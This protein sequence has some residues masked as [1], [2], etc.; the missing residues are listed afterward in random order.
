MESSIGTN[1][2]TLRSIRTS[3]KNVGEERKRTTVL[4]SYGKIPKAG[5]EMVDV[6]VAMVKKKQQEFQTRTAKV[7]AELT[8]AAALKHH[9]WV[10]LFNDIGKPYLATA[11]FDG[12]RQ[13]IDIGVEGLKPDT[14]VW[15][16][17]K[18]LP[19]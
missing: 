12:V 10:L 8:T 5:E 18:T 7:L 13:R 2:E 16:V 19:N 9:D 14:P 15:K 6:L 3:G 1:T 4:Q 11:T 17:V